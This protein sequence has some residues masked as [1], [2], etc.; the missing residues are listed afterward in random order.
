MK[1]PAFWYRPPRLAA[2]LLSPLA[3]LYDGAGVVR[4]S[5]VGGRAAGV[6]VVCV[7]N[8]VA[9]GAGKTPV[10]LAV[11][12]RLL[13]QERRPHLLSRGYRGRLRGPVQVDLGRHTAADVGDEPLLLAALAPTWVARDRIAGARAAAAAGADLVVLD[14]GHQNP[15]LHKDLALVVVDGET[16]FG[17]RRVIPAGPLR[18]RIKR[19]LARADAIVLM[20]DDT[21]RVGELLAW[22]GR[23][24]L[25]ARLVAAGDAGWLRGADVVAFA[26]I[27]RPDKFFSLL[28]RLGGRLAARFAYPDHHRFDADELMR[29][30]ELAAAAGAHLVTT[31]KD[32]ARLPEEARPMTRVVAVRVIWDEPAVLDGLLAD[33]LDQ[34]AREDPVP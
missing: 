14:D 3:A 4:H 5:L 1:A 24:V 32:Y 11:A 16:G 22:R 15:T 20:G 17:N 19:G 9:G 13:A 30:V 2:A 7:G 8:L 29:M 25:G 23:P 26:G 28:E 27:G 34:A 21:S 6:P 12:E 31:A 18:E 10:A 33:V